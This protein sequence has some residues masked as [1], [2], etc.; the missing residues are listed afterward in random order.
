MNQPDVAGLDSAGS[1]PASRL[2]PHSE[3]NTSWTASTQRG[4][5]GDPILVSKME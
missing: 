3:N 5:R 4:D 1:G 2:P